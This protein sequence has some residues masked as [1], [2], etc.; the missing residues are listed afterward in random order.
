M[1]ALSDMNVENNNNC[2]NCDKDETKKQMQNGQI[3]DENRIQET[4]L[5]GE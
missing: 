1:M 4:T 3:G 5:D 2:D